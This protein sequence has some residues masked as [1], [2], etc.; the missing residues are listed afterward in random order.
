ML[1]PDYAAKRS[2]EEAREIELRLT[3]LLHN[4]STSKISCM[5]KSEV[6]SIAYKRVLDALTELKH[7]PA[8]FKD[9]EN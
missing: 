2:N 9:Q 3:A 7:Q 5:N 1:Y 4:I 8:R 6:I